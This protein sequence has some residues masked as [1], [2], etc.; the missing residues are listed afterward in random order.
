[1]HHAA[2]KTKWTL[3]YT[4]SGVKRNFET[5]EACR[6]AAFEC[7]GVCPVRVIPPIYGDDE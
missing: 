2:H 7:E 1:M 6:S 3:L 5:R 4:Q